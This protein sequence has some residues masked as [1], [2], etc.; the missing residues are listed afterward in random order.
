MWVPSIVGGGPWA[1]W[2]CAPTLLIVGGNDPPAIEMNREALAK[3]AC[4]K[5]TGHPSGRWPLFEEPGMLEEVAK[6]TAEWL[7]QHFRTVAGF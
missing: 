3:L 4:E 1:P 7:S 2:V 6:T 5:K